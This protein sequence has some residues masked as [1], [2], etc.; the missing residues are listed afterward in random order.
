[1]LVEEAAQ[2]AFAEA[3]AGGKR[4]HRGLV[5][6]PALDE[7]QRARHGVR[8]P[9]QAPRAGEVSGRQRRHGRKPAACAAA[10]VG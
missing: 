1:M 4:V 9:C 2:L 5:E 8:V 3:E 6:R 10:A 7:H